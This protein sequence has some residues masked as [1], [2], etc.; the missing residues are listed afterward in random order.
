MNEKAART[1]RRVG[2]EVVVE[3]RREVVGDA[4]LVLQF[5]RCEK[6]VAMR[7][8]FQGWANFVVAAWISA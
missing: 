6:W 5:G 3:S 4:K 8:V 7:I 2:Q 1:W